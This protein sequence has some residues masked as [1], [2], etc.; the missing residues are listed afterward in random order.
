MSEIERIAKKVAVQIKM[1]QDHDLMRSKHFNGLIDKEIA[2]KKPRVTYL[3]AHN[4][5]FNES[6]RI[7]E[8]SY[9]MMELTTEWNTIKAKL[10]AS[11]GED[12]TTEDPKAFAEALSELRAIDTKHLFR[13]CSLIKSNRR[14]RKFDTPLR[15]DLLNQYEFMR[16]VY[17]NAP[18][19]LKRMGRSEAQRIG[20]QKRSASM[21]MRWGCF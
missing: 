1:L 19:F 5:E 3:E 11:S 16:R 12:G 13:M 21:K 6:I 18:K 20:D 10:D 4:K 7:G 14:W 8:A 15:N 17:K 9:K 2:R